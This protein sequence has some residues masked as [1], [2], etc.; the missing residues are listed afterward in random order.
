MSFFQC[1]A[2]ALVFLLTVKQI[3]CYRKAA[4]CLNAHSA[5]M[6]LSARGVTW[7]WNYGVI[8]N[9]LIA[10]LLHN[11]SA[12][13]LLTSRHTL[14]NICEVW[15]ILSALK[16]HAKCVTKRQAMNQQLFH[17]VPPFPETGA[18]WHIHLQDM[19]W[20]HT[21][22]KMQGSWCKTNVDPKS[23]FHRHLSICLLIS[24]RE[25]VQTELMSG[26]RG[27]NICASKY[28]PLSALCMHHITDRRKLCL[29]LK[30]SH[31]NNANF[32]LL[33]ELRCYKAVELWSQVLLW[34]S[35]LFDAS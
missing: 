23:R 7:K 17:P 1:S 5:A 29:Q 4:K 14:G 13:F 20:G 26:S 9:M 6:A 12:G 2:I 11:Q 34:K 31:A 16:I 28:R 27:K 30:C 33:S 25:S 24:R 19:S 3:P 21:A 10:H 8:P 18:R 35:A 15:E 22:T 32:P